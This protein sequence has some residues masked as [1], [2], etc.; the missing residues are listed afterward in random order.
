MATAHGVS[1]EV[2]FRALMSDTPVRADHGFLRS[3]LDPS[4]AALL[5]TVDRVHSEDIMP[6]GVWEALREVNSVGRLSRDVPVGQVLSLLLES[7]AMLVAA[8]Q[9]R[10]DAYIKGEGEVPC[11]RRAAQRAIHVADPAELI[12]A[13][14]ADQDFARAVAAVRAQIAHRAEAVLAVAQEDARRDPRYEHLNFD[15]SAA[16]VV[17]VPYDFEPALAKV[18]DKAAVGALADE[19]SLWGVVQQPLSQL[20]S[21]GSSA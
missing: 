7:V 4:L 20:V 10:T 15:P 6:F 5:I 14:L 3:V 2:Q 21:D 11:W 9:T 16:G 18:R 17:W 1:E 19:L 13:A 8:E 12:V